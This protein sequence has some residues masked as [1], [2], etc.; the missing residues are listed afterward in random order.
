MD[1]TPII[2]IVFN[3]LLFFLLS[4]SY[5]Q[6]SALDVK[7]PKAATSEGV[8]GEVVIV[9][10]NRQDQI[11]LQGKPVEGLED[12]EKRL[13]AI[14]SN[15]GAEE[16]KPLL[17]RADEFVYHGRVVSVLDIARKVGVQSLNVATVPSEEEPSSSDP[18]AE[19][20]KKDA[21]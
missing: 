12:L 4:S 9:E 10:L 20:K 6:H 19:S 14:Y 1:M 17:I 8:E 7:L 15:A 13:G 3:L 2:D 11:F 18:N 16:K 21:S 5:V